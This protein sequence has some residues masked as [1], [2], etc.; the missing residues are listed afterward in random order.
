MINKLRQ[1]LVLIMILFSVTAVIGNILVGNDSNVLPMLMFV[2][3][4]LFAG[5]E[6]LKDS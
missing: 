5:N 3:F 6:I 1:I 4:S 2:A